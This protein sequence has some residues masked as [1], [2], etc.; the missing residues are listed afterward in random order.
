MSLFD[1]QDV[2]IVIGS[3][4]TLDLPM[5]VDLIGIYVL[6]GPNYT[7]TTTNWFLQALSVIP[8]GSWGDVSRR[9][10]MIRWESP[11]L[12]FRSHNG[13]G[14]T[15]S[16]IP[17]PLRVTQRRPLLSKSSRPPPPPPRRRAAA[18]VIGLVPITF[19][20]DSVRGKNSSALLVQ[21][22]EGLVLLVVDLIKEDLPPP[23]LKSQIPCEFGWSQAPRRQ[24]GRRPPPR[25]AAPS[26]AGQH[27]MS[28]AGRP[29]CASVAHGGAWL[30]AILGAAMPR[31]S[32][33]ACVLLPHA[34]C[35]RR[36]PSGVFPGSVA[37]TVLSSRFCS[38]LSRVAHEV[39]GPIFDIGP[40]LVGPKIDFEIFEIL[41][42]KLF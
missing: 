37:M 9:F 16:C 17:E 20:G 22:D 8:R 15:A 25:A 40:I 35:W 38:G 21:T 41:D 39:F 42:L 5:V 3:L 29:P 4:A 10:T 31:T 32:L 11:K 27:A 14:P 6:K 13:C 36:P 34:V 19:R 33:P 1:L 30:C 23:T 7:L 26:R 12:R 28:R 24:Q 2:C 18:A